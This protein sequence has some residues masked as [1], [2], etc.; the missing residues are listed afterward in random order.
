MP[1]ICTPFYNAN[2]NE[3]EALS[4]GLIKGYVIFKVDNCNTILKCPGEL[5]KF[6]TNYFYS[7]I[8][9]INFSTHYETHTR[10]RKIPATAS[11]SLHYRLRQN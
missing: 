7:L 8:K 5:I 1:E 10:K 11:S 6:E 3:D 9:N 4:Q 2:G